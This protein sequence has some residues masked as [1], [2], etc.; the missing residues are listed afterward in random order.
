[1]TL[2]PVQPPPPKLAV[3]IIKTLIDATTAVT[4]GRRQKIAISGTDFLEKIGTRNIRRQLPS[5]SLSAAHSATQQAIGRPGSAHHSL[6][7]LAKKSFEVGTATITDTHEAQ[8]QFELDLAQQVQVEMANFNRVTVTLC[9]QA[10]G[11]QALRSHSQVAY[12]N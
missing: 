5:G 7:E 3:N 11:D 4:T 9:W 1:M 6:H 12:I 8:A 2:I 10:P